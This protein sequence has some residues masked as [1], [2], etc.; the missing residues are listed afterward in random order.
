M[1]F[2]NHTNYSAGWTLGFEPDGR[3]LLVV[4]IKATFR[5]SQ[6]GGSPEPAEDQ[7]P[8]IDADEF[9]GEPGY[10][11]TLYETDYA[12]R[13]PFCDV[14]LNGSAYAPDGRPSKSVEVGLQVGNIKKAFN[15][16]GDRLWDRIMMVNSPTSPIPF[17]RKPIS[18]DRA[19]GGVDKDH[20]DEEKVKTYALNPVGIGYYP[21][22]SGK[23]LEGKP[24]PNTEEVG[25]PINNSKAGK[26]KPMAFGPL[27]RNFVPRVKYAGTYDQNWLD[28]QAPF[29]PDDFDYL[30]F[31]SAPID[32]RIAYP[33]GGERVILQNLTP[34]GVSTFTLPKLDIPVLMVPY[35]GKAKQMRPVIDTVLIEP[36]L[37][38]FT[39]TVRISY[40]LG[41]N[42]FELKDVIVG[43]T[44][45]RWRRKQLAGSK[46]YYKGIAGF[47]KAQ[48]A[49]RP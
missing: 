20:K 35:K 12:H 49:R 36:D 21:L 40:P 11:A 45:K 44:M 34:I 46:P 28:N 24:L 14:L 7:A 42:C 8:L 10:S 5:I 4:A 2:E 32:Q 27:G 3:E 19:Y 13:K 22:S 30:Y 33:V 43:E 41:R 31:Q 25:K 6:N 23:Q 16:I 39:M 15:V 1:N 17:V 48:K 26:F 38:C 9:S 47:I 18:Y 37:E 29:W